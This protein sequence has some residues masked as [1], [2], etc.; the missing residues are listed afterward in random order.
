MTKADAEKLITEMLQN[1]N[2]RSHC[3]AAGAAMGTLFDH[4][5]VE[6]TNEGTTREDW[7]ISGMLHDVDYEVTEKSAE[8]HTEETTEK[9]KEY[10]E[11]DPESKDQI[12]RIIQAVRGHANKAVRETLMAKAIYAAD[13]LTGLIVAAALVRPDKK[14]EG[15][16]VDSVLKRFKEPSFAKGADREM[17]KTCETELGLPLDVFTQ[18]VLD[19]MKKID[20]QLGL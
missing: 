4:F 16:T 10:I 11:N 19:A 1:K 5:E 6:A 3:Y 17:I 12:D 15:L 9:L 18:I 7:E 8:R 13:E 14:L 20:D 2:L